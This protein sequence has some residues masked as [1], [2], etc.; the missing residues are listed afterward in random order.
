LHSSVDGAEVSLSTSVVTLMSD[1][2]LAS[3]IIPTVCRHGL[4]HRHGEREDWRSF[5][6]ESHV[7]VVK[8]SAGRSS[9]QIWKTANLNT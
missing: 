8:S 3:L 9:L 7:D 2:M 1:M 5:M 6:E 4:G